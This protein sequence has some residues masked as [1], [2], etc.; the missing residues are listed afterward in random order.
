MVCTRVLHFFSLQEPSSNSLSSLGSPTSTPT[1]PSLG[2]NPCLARPVSV[3]PQP[4]YAHSLSAAAG[5]LPRGA[6]VLTAHGAGVNS[7]GAYG[8]AAVPGLANHIPVADVDA[9]ASAVSVSPS[10][11]AALTALLSSPPA[12]YIPATGIAACTTAAAAPSVGVIGTPAGLPAIDVGHS[13]LQPPQQPPSSP[14]TPT[15]IAGSGAM[16]TMRR[17]ISGRAALL[18]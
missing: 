6:A 2:F 18:C 17:S 11:L 4:G 14:T 13:V 1:N 16:N 3:S 12:S 9:A 8:P 5:V 7:F 15:G 10:M